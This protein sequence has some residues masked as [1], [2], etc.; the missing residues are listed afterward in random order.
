MS[1]PQ[2]PA[3]DAAAY[4]ALEEIADGDCSDSENAKD[5]SFSRTVIMRT[6]WFEPKLGT[7]RICIGGVT[8]TICALA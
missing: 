5:S 1:E 6:L 8:R 4:Q 3:I 7:A 2:E